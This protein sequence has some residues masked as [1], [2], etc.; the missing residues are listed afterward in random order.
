MFK[1]VLTFFKELVILITAIIIAEALTFLF[2][3]ANS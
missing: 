1:K 2:L 3:W